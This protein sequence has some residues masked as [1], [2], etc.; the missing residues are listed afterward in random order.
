LNVATTTKE[1]LNTLC[2]RAGTP[3][4]LAKLHTI[5]STATQLEAAF[6]QQSI[7]H[8]LQKTSEVFASESRL[9]GVGLT[10]MTERGDKKRTLFDPQANEALVSAS[11]QGAA[12]SLGKL[13]D[14]AQL[15]Y[16]RLMGVV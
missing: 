9:N 3:Q 7:E 4:R 14:V 15:N 12:E 16:G 6:W 10:P 2:L 11:P 1:Y 8:H 5:F 13:D